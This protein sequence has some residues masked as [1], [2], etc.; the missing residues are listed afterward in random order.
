MIAIKGPRA[1]KGATAVTLGLWLGQPVPWLDQPT[2]AGTIEGSIRPASVAARTVFVISVED[3]DATS[4]PS[5]K[6][7]I[8]D[9]RGLRFEPHVL[10]IQ[11][12]TTVEFPN[13]D[14]ISHNIFS[15]SPAKR[16]NVGLYPHGSTRRMTF[17]QPGVVE[18]LCDI[19][20]EMSAYIVVLRNQYFSQTG[21]DG[22]YRISGVPS[23]RHLVRLWNEKLG[24][25]ERIVQVLRGGSATLD[26]RIVE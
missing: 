24:A 4:P 26:F 3:I 25:Q 20:L 14:P 6:V 12:G 23:G 2:P 21:P 8:M 10:A 16:F 22:S 18:L 15:I 9:Q 13:S 1:L 11:A 19:H 5:G 7:A 17:D